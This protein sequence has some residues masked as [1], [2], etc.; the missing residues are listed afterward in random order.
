MRTFDGSVGWPALRRRFAGRL[1]EATLARLDA[2]L[3]FAVARHGGQTRPAG[4]PYIEHLLEAVTVLVEAV[5]VTDVDTLCAAVLHDVVEDTETSLDEVRE[6]FGERVAELVDWV[7]KPAPEPGQ[8]A[9]AARAEYMLRLRQAPEMAIVIKLADRLSNVQRLDTH[10]RPQK[11]TTYYGE[12]RASIVP[13]AKG[14]PWFQR[15]YAD[16][17]KHFE[18]LK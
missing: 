1:A 4:E 2:A 13:L 11:R 15:W 18:Y 17:E 5:D 8:D 9:D 10:P 3:D 16:W 6:R 7:T 12:T 14:H